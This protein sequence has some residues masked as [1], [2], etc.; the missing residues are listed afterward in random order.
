MGMSHTTA[1]VTIITQTANHHQFAVAV[2]VWSLVV[3]LG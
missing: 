2:W 1:A 3:F